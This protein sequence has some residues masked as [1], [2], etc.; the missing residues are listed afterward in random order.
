MQALIEHFYT[1]FQMK[2][3]KG[4]NSCY[5]EE[6]E[7][8]DPAFGTLKGED[9]KSMWEMLCKN[10]VDF[11]LEFS[12][13]KANKNIGRAHWE[14][15]YTFSKT[16]R[17]VHNIIDAQFE[18]KDGKIVKHYDAFNLHRWAKQALGFKGW[19]LGGTVFFKKKIQQQTRKS[20][21]SYKRNIKNNMT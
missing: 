14:A 3:A 20:L 6:I 2:D 11:K 10:A 4:M 18:W 5:H 1:S 9:V 13:V 21:D 16:G 12:D 17:A 15:W 19:L 8:T 7:F